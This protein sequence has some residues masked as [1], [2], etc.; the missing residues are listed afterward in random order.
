[1]PIQIKI[2]IHERNASY[3]SAEINTNW[4]ESLSENLTDKRPPGWANGDGHEIPLFCKAT[5]TNI[6]LPDEDQD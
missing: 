4:R 3:L 1:L 6:S 2:L 5:V